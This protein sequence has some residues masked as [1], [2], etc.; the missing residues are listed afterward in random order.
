MLPALA[1]G[2]FVLLRGGTLES[3]LD[4][5]TPPLPA[6]AIVAGVALLQA[7]VVAL[8]L[9]AGVDPL[10][11]VLPGVACVIAGALFGRLAGLPDASR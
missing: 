3:G 8:N 7:A 5:R 2:L 10:V 6:L 4:S 11:A 1:A 9:G